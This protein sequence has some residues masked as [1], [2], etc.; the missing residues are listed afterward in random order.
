MWIWNFNICVSILSAGKDLSLDEMV[1]GFKGRFRYK[2]YNATK[3]SK[4]HIKTFGL[5]D[6]ETGY[7]CNMFTYYGSETPYHPDSDPD[8]SMGE[9]IWLRDT[10]SSLL[11]STPQTPP[12]LSVPKFP[13]LHRNC[14]HPQKELSFSPK[15]NQPQ[16]AW[17]PV[18]QV[19]RRQ[20]HCCSIPRQEGQEMC[21]RSHKF[22]G[23]WDYACENTR[24]SFCRQ[25]C[26]H[27]WL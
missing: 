9:K 17:G 7:V 4:Y 3:P 22:W 10:I 23:G 12:W 5:C 13:L 16:K 14:W 21:C 25:T 18:V 24:R 19:G 26:L 15:K 11:G 6:S 8:G 1:V 27:W 2:Q 20:I